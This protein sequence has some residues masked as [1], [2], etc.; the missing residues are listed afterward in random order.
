MDGCGIRWGATVADA[1]VWLGG[2]RH[3]SVTVESE[4]LASPLNDG[5]FQRFADTAGL[6]AGGG[7]SCARG[8]GRIGMTMTV[9]ARG[10]DEAADRAA[11]AFKRA[12]EA[13]LW[14]RYEPST[15]AD[16]RVQVVPAEPALA[17][18]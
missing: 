8:E 7:A 13:A 12:L 18:A 4:M 6:E 11:L 3:W 9:R 17:A 15:S 16:W 2:H 14:P 1:K 10:I 5:A